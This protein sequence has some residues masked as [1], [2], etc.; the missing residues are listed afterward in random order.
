LARRDR[1]LSM[2]Q[3]ETSELPRITV[4]IMSHRHGRILP[5]TEESIFEN[6]SLRERAPPV[7]DAA[8]FNQI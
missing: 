3:E 2:S 6:Y 8:E 4:G 5:A 1:R 7:M